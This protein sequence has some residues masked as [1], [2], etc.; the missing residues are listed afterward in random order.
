MAKISYNG[1]QYLCEQ[2]DSVL[3]TLLQANIPIP[4]SCRGGVCQS[5]LMR[6]LDA[7]PPAVAQNG[8][9]DTLQH[10]KYFLACSCYPEQDMTVALPESEGLAFSA[11]VVNKEKLSGDIVRLVLAFEEEFEFL[12]G[13]F[14]NLIRDDGLTRSYSIA[15]V[16]E[17]N[18]ILEL[19]VRRLPQGKFSTWVHDELAIGE[20]LTVSEAKG[21]CHYLPGRAEQPLLLIGTGSGLAPL[22]G[23]VNDALNQG[24]SGTI[25]LFHG[26][27]F[28]E[29]LYLVEAMKKLDR[30]YDNFE[31]IPCVSGEIDSSEFAKGRV[32]DVALSS[33]DSL[34][35]WKVFLCGHPEMVNQSKKMAYLKGVSLSDIYADAFYTEQTR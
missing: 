18:K 33:S 20:Q 1:V 26:S 14:V 15:N 29:G 10:Q 34:T 21:N 5:C 4:N 30:A 24:H 25:R 12:A 16:P 23:I 32:H 27:R 17:Q 22:Y 35:G 11:R 7:K 2:G 31:Y 13:Q 6:S 28:P 8:L 3:D 19:H 9:K